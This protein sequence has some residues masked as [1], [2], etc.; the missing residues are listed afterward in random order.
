MMELSR[1]A[2]SSCPACGFALFHPVASLE[3]SHLG[4]YSDK[5]FPGRSL[6]IS[7]LHYDDI[8]EMPERE[9]LRF[10]NDIRRATE[11]LKILTGSGRVNVSILGNTESHVHAHLIPRYPENELF[12][13]KSPWNDPRQQEPLTTAEIAD[14][15]EKLAGIL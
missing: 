15:S 3:V 12:P 9:Y 14:M 4:I 8:S 6:L 2:G 7:D 11:A 10:C 1:T 5:R 13:G